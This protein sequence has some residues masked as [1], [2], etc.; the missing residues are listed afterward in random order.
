MSTIVQ[1]LYLLGHE[2]R[3]RLGFLSAIVPSDRNDLE[4]TH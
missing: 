1:K 3:F 4:A 2:R